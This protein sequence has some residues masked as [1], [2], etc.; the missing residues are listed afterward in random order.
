MVIG[1]VLLK[2][3][4]KYKII[5]LDINQSLIKGNSQIWYQH[6]CKIPQILLISVSSFAPAYVGRIWV[7][8]DVIK[9]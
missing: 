2:R 5:K 6:V 8:S 3:F 4:K 1:I 9:G 7:K